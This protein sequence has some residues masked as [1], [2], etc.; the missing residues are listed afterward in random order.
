MKIPI[1]AKYVVYG[2]SVEAADDN[3]DRPSFQM[4][5]GFY[6]YDPNECYLT[7][8]QEEYYNDLLGDPVSNDKMSYSNSFSLKMLFALKQINKVVWIILRINQLLYT[9]KKLF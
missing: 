7:A 8:P 1:Y 6:D 3:P 4:G 9:K 2:E 5:E